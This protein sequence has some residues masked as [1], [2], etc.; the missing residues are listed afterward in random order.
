[1]KRDRGEQ[2]MRSIRRI[3][4]IVILASIDTVRSKR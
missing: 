3:E 2:C 4:E 1:M